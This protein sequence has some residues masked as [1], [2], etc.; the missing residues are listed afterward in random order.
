MNTE[1]ICQSGFN[2]LPGMREFYQQVKTIATSTN[3]DTM[4]IRSH[5]AYWSGNAMA[6]AA[7]ITA[8]R[9]HSYRVKLDRDFK[10]TI[11]KIVDHYDHREGVT[12]WKD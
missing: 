6:E 11:V 10:G 1:H 7:I 3:A 2:H 8:S 12:G 4:L 9:G 5:I